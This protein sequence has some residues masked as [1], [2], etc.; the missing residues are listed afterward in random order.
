MFF[1]SLLYVIQTITQSNFF[2]R[3][4]F[5]GV[6]YYKLEIS[7]F[8]RIQRFVGLLLHTG[9]VRMPKLQDCSKKRLTAKNLLWGL[10][11]SREISLYFKLSALC[12]F[13]DDKKDQLYQINPVTHHSNKKIHCYGADV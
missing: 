11:V 7:N 8:R 10:Y 4:D 12:I 6:P 9:V 5:G 3:S 2:V 13:E 1:F